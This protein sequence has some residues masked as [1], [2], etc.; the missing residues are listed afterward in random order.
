[1][2]RVPPEYPKALEYPVLRPFLPKYYV[3]EFGRLADTPGAEK[4]G[5]TLPRTVPHNRKLFETLTDVC[6]GI[7]CD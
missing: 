6:I 2:D 4:E 7:L 3:R 5:A 1:M